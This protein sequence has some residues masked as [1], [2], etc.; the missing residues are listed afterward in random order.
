MCVCEVEDDERMNEVGVTRLERV[1]FEVG[2]E[3]FI[4]GT[5]DGDSASSLSG[6]DSSGV[7]SMCDRS[8]L[9]VQ[10]IYGT[11]ART[12]M[13]QLGALGTLL[14]EFSACICAVTTLVASE[15]TMIGVSLL[16]WVGQVSTLS[17]SAEICIR[18]VA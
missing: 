10:T 18:V 13:T 15:A 11:A 6:D 12:V 17:Q 7:C 2:V 8:W 5:G 16:L 4:V 1:Y 3:C 9:N 14:R